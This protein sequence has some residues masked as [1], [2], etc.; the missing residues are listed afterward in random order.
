MIIELH[1]VKLIR[2]IV[3]ENE[4]YLVELVPNFFTSAMAYYAMNRIEKNLFEKFLME[5]DVASLPVSAANNNPFSITNFKWCNE[6]VGNNP[7]QSMAIRHIV[8]RKNFPSPY[9]VFGPPG[10]GKTSTLV[11]TVAQIVKLF[12]SLKV[13]ITANSNSAC[14]EIGDRLIK[15]VGHN[16]IF[17]YYSPSFQRKMNRVHPKLQSCSNLR[18]GFHTQP[19]VQELI[20]YNVVIC[21][22]VNAGRM[23]KLPADLFDFVFVDECASS[24]EAYVT[25][26]LSLTMSNQLPFKASIV[27]LGDPKQLG[28]IMK[29]HHC[30]R[31]K[32]NVSM[33][34]RVMA[35]EKYKFN[36]NT[37][38]NPDLI[39]QLV[40][41]FRSHEAIL[42]FSNKNFYNSILKARQVAHIANFAVGWNRLPN[43][44]VPLIFR[45]SWTPSQEDGTSHFN[46]G[47]IHLIKCYIYSMTNIG[48]NGKKIAC[49]DI[50]VISPYA[51]QR[52]KLKSA[53]PPD[54]EI[55]TVEYFQGRE[56]LIIIMSC[57]R[58]KTRTIGFLSNEKR[59]NVALTRAKG[60]LI[61]V[62][63]PETLGKNKLWRKFMTSCKLV[64]AIEGKV[65]AW[66]IKRGMKDL[67]KEEKDADEVVR[68]EE[69]MDGLV[70][71]D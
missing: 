15:Y 66:M 67:A 35:M 30:E 46:L 33:M 28:Q 36:E 18:Q 70:I 68:L 24:A 34:E 38:Y 51:T 54:V 12:P 10:T 5:F 37:G 44:Q 23:G 59:L 56:K 21:T 43:P 13:L 63:N 17:R 50:G 11:E 45:A 39:T 57:V 6:S 1:D 53:L 4:S 16:K 64:N 52:E 69:Y 62:G 31:Y 19:S 61:V 20:S 25:I 3:S 26:P 2:K 14:D 40:D 29:T 48:I 22:L 41:N 47:D 60:L 49:S 42:D 55:G 27:L 8:N 71:E 32:F 9:I 7:S 58:S 65:P